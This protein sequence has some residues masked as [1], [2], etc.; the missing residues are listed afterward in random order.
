[1]SLY[2]RYDHAKER[3]AALDTYENWLRGLIDGTA[4]DNVVQLELKTIVS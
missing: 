2:Q 4:G 1:M 3:L